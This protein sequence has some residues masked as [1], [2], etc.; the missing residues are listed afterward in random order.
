V[1]IFVA[2]DSA[3]NLE[4]NNFGTV[5][6]AEFRHTILRSRYRIGLTVDA[7]WLVNERDD[8][9]YAVLNPR[10]LLKFTTSNTPHPN[11]KQPS[12]ASWIEGFCSWGRNYE[13]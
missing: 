9:V 2:A 7:I 6:V 3:K 12:I 11:N 5:R 4:I 1:A 10:F 8:R 13:K